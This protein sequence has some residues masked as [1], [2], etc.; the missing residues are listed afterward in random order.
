MK[1]TPPKK[2]S[3]NQ[4]FILQHLIAGWKITSTKEGNYVI[5]GPQG[6]S[7]TVYGGTLWFLQRNGYLDEEYNVTESGL[8]VVND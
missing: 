2:P 1:K 6:F 3:S 4:L 7:F 8:E 5:I